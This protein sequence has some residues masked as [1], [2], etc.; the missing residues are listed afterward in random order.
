MTRETR[1]DDHFITWKPE[2]SVHIESIDRQHQALVGLI[3]QLQEAMEEGRGRSFQH[4]LVDRLV[5]F[6]DIHFKFE[7][8]LMDERGY[9]QLTAHIEQHR[10]LIEQ[11]TQIQKKLQDREPISN[12]SLMSFLRHWLTDHIMDHD[13]KYAQAFRSVESP[14]PQTV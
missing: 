13:Q 11:V 2:Y 1:T 12:A 10:I 5:A 8:D 4:T 7:E 6:I 3:R 14:A 9:D